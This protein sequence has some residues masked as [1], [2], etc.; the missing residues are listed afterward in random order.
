MSN[1]QNSIILNWLK[2]NR[3]A[4]H[5]QHLAVGL[6]EFKKP[7]LTYMSVPFRVIPVFKNSLAMFLHTA[8]RFTKW[9]MLLHT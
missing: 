5:A 9:Y 8:S 4:Q 6:C 7:Q 1:V 2:M 3:L